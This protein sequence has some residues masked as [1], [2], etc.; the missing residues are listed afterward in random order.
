[1][2]HHARLGD[3]AELPRRL[4]SRALVPEVCRKKPQPP[5]FLRSK[6]ITFFKLGDSKKDYV[7]HTLCSHHVHIEFKAMKSHI[8]LNILMFQTY[9]ISCRS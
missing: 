3:P 8:V 9:E 4:G 1:M 5:I 2:A 7:H 6:E